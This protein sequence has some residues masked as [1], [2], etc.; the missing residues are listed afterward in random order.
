MSD[1][2]KVQ[3]YEFER[4][5]TTFDERHV[6]EHEKIDE[7]CCLQFMEPNWNKSWIVIS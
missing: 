3:I 6:H 2:R 7:S 4:F 5:P 1:D